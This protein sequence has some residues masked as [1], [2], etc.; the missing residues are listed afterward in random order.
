V[1]AF[2]IVGLLFL[3]TA[4]AIESDSIRVCV[5]WQGL[6]FIRSPYSSLV[7]FE[8]KPES[9]RSHELQKG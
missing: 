2:T 4:S 8:E 7:I 9:R 1:E 3:G 6:L 5:F